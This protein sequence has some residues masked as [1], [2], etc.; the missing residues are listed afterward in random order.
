MITAGIILGISYLVF[1]A[2]F[3][4]YLMAST[5]PNQDWIGKS[6]FKDVGIIVVVFLFVTLAW[7]YVIKNALRP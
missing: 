1:G 3:A 6:W 5:Y 4:L 7:P 2:A